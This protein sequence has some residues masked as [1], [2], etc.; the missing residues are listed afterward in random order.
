M[1]Y[2]EWCGPKLTSPVPIRSLPHV[3]SPGRPSLVSHDRLQ[4]SNDGAA[5]FGSLFADACLSL[6]LKDPQFSV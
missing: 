3:P 5:V 2:S 6:A 4:M 1:S